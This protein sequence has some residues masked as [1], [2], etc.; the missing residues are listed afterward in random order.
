M[1]TKKNVS[2]HDF[3]DFENDNTN[4][5]IRGRAGVHANVMRERDNCWLRSAAPE[6]QSI[7]NG[8]VIEKIIYDLTPGAIYLF[9]L[10]T[11]H[12][13]TGGEPTGMYPFIFIKTGNEISTQP[14]EIVDP[15]WKVH[16]VQ[17]HAHTS[18]ILIQLINMSPGGRRNAFD[19][20]DIFIG[21]PLLDITTFDDGLNGWI[22]GDL[23]QTGTIT[24]LYGMSVFH[25]RG[26]S[27]PSHAGAVLSKDFTLIHQ[28]EYVFRISVRRNNQGSPKPILSLATTTGSLTEPT[29][30]EFGDWQ[31]LE[32]RFRAERAIETLSIVSHQMTSQAND[33]SI[34]DIQ[35]FDY[36]AR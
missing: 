30:V 6:S 19:M 9:S 20:T 10:R 28:R 13:D 25:N 11:R 16:L 35:V 27:Q 23:G 26:P 2:P 18:K 12:C 5:W 3:T 7:S 33:Y 22:Q 36:L 1:N 15:E 34:G 21:T 29:P 32:S 14:I 31:S 8:V 17:F 4:G 24:Q